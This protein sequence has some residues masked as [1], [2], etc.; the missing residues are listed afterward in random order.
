MRSMEQNSQSALLENNTTG[1]LSLTSSIRLTT[2][3]HIGRICQ[4][5]LYHS[6][7]RTVFK[8]ESLQ[9]T[10]RSSARGDCSFFSS[11]RVPDETKD[12]Y[13]ISMS[14]SVVRLPIVFLRQPQRMMLDRL[15]GK[16]NVRMH[17]TGDVDQGISPG[18][19]TQDCT[20]DSRQ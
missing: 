20:V 2:R 13:R 5:T 10:T 3:A 17:C 1:P 11:T 12:S 19:K 6:S 15:L 9:S 4:L 18:A 14:L 7:D 16:G 8:M